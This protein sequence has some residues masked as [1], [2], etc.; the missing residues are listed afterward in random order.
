MIPYSNLR[1]RPRVDLAAAIPLDE[2]LTVYVEPTNKCNLSCDFCPQFLS[3]YE[4]R[5]GYSE[6]M[7][8]D[9]FRKVADELKAMHLASL[10]LYFFGEPLMHPAIAEICRLS[11]DV[12]DRVELT[13]NAIPFTDQKIIDIIDSGIHYIRVSWYGEK[14]D[15]VRENVRKLW[16]ARQSR[17]RTLPWI[18][19][20]IHSAAQSA[21]VESLKSSCDEIITEQLHTIG[22]DFVQLRSYARNKKAC[23]YPF[24]N[25]VVKSNGDVVPCC[26]A[27]EQSLV[28]GNVRD[29]T[30][31]DIWRGQPMHR[32]RMMHLQGRSSELAACAQC[33]TGYNCPDS[34]DSVSAA[35]YEGR[36]KSL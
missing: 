21:D 33:D 19:V 9:L 29:Q 27:W 2:P 3:D 15:R 18:A 26:V 10:K 35:D 6:H 31:R 22:S 4:E 16:E 17:G 5:A 23:P 7:P 25:L 14:A 30:L 36:V 13:T 24:Y 34:V 1:K 28:V 20:K 8:V 11:A 32:I 12:C